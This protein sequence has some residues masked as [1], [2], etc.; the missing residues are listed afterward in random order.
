MNPVNKTLKTKHKKWE[1]VEEE[2]E[3]LRGGELGED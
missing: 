2:K 1:E 3:G